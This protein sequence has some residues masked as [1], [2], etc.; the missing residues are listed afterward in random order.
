MHLRPAVLRFET[1]DLCWQF[2]NVLRTLG[3]QPTVDQRVL[4]ALAGQVT[5]GG[6]RPA[7]QMC[8]EGRTVVEQAP[9]P[10]VSP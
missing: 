10:D 7:Q 3:G 6:L 1:V 9:R 4:A 2:T 8:H 5:C